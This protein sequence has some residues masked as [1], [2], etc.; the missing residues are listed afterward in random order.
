[1][2]RL[3]ETKTELSE[4]N[5]QIGTPTNAQD[6]AEVIM[7]IISKFILIGQNT[8]LNAFYGTYHFSNEG[9]CTWYDFVKKIFNIYK[10]NI[11]LHP[12]P[13]SGF[14]TPAKR[15]FYSVFDKGKIKTVFGL[16]ISDWEQ[17]IKSL[18]TIK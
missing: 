1:M 11:D 3:A 15:H 17:A 10:I 12:L 13:T 6:L 4:V 14:P 2:L 9:Q 7:Q 5:D 8:E 18:L 16:N